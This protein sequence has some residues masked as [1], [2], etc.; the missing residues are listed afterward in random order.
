MNQTALPRGKT[1]SLKVILIAI[2]L[3]MAATAG[4]MTYLIKAVPKTVSNSK[5]GLFVELTEQL[6][7]IYESG[8]GLKPTADYR[9]INAAMLQNLQESPWALRESS[10]WTVDS[11]SQTQVHQ[12][13]LL[14][15]HYHDVENRSLLLGF[16]PISKRNFPK[17]GGFSYKDAWF[18]TFGRDH[19][20][21]VLPE[22]L[23]MVEKLQRKG[24]NLV[25]TN[26]GND[27]LIG[28]L[29]SVDSKKL[30]KDLF[31]MSSIYET[32]S[33]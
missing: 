26:Y 19:T 13:P 29:S 20:E 27:F 23:V 2:S 32:P 6:V 9:A 33:Q 17:S 16:I 18:M 8:E 3:A 11:W 5:A 30:A 22:H 25:A 1:Y 10:V 7:S 15:V 24:L 28:M 14:L 21:A 4:Y 31:A 12:R